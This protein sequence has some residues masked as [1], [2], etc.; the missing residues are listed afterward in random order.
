[1]SRWLHVSRLN[2]KNHSSRWL[3]SLINTNRLG[4]SRVVNAP[5]NCF[6]F[7]SLI[8]TRGTPVRSLTVLPPKRESDL[9]ND[10]LVN[11]RIE[12]PCEPQRLVSAESRNAEVKAKGG[13]LKFRQT[14]LDLMAANDLSQCLTFIQKSDVGDE[15]KQESAEG[16]LKRA[17]KLGCPDVAFSLFSKILASPIKPTMKMYTTLMNAC[18]A[19]RDASR[20][21]AVFDFVQR[22][23][24][25][26]NKRCYDILIKTFVFSG[27]AEGAL[28]KMD[29]MEQ[30][31]LL[32]DVE[33]LNSVIRVCA[34]RSDYYAS[35]FAL[36]ERM[37]VQ[38]L[39]PNVYTYHALLTATAK[40]GDLE[41]ASLIW[42]L[43]SSANL[44]NLSLFNVLLQNFAHAL[45]PQYAQ[46]LRRQNE[47][48]RLP[49]EQFLATKYNIIV[50]KSEL[51]AAEDSPPHTDEGV[52]LELVANPSTKTANPLS[53]AFSRTENLSD[54]LVRETNRLLRTFFASAYCKRGPAVSMKNR[55]QG[56]QVDPF[57]I[58]IDQFP[59]S[60]DPNLTARWKLR[61]KEQAEQT[62]NNLQLPS[63]KLV[64]SATVTCLEQPVSVRNALVNSVLADRVLDVYCSAGGTEHRQRAFAIFENIYRELQVSKGGLAYD[65]IWQMCTK[66]RKMMEVWGETLFL[67]MLEWGTLFELALKECNVSPRERDMLRVSFGHTPQQWFKRFCRG[68]N[69]FA[70]VNQLDKAIDL[71]YLAQR[72]NHPHFLSQVCFRHVP[73]L[74]KKA[75]DQRD[76]GNREYY[77]KLVS[78]CPQRPKLNAYEQVVAKIAFQR[79]AATPGGT[80]WGWR[81][82]NVEDMGQDLEQVRK[83]RKDEKANKQRLASEAKESQ[84]SVDQILSIKR[85]PGSKR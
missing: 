7:G 18:Y 9:V 77:R 45:A 70:R 63:E 60:S 22:E 38:G 83:L 19:A 27:Q 46:R 44:I 69:G 65:R 67:E 72:Y 25:L 21:K 13:S 14:V 3:F 33:T 55:F 31:G 82:K 20:A 40:N 32:P 76:D 85:A 58:P 74:V 62:F 57:K 6:C 68:V 78:L 43:L 24:S 4:G 41:R 51:D 80:H 81:P 11:T 16:V 53:L 1:M 47:G 66:D 50:P 73:T 42:E 71:L 29:E 26:P 30:L 23:I 48:K 61:T 75:A 54:S 12:K 56:L 64:Q 15:L 84:L 79:G 10:L 52:D 5:F 17:V 8:A 34:H 49:T 39:K 37:V 36:F 28:E 59:F 2:S 35:C